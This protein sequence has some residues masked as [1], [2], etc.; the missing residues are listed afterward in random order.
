V[1]GR[2]SQLLVV[3]L[4]AGVVG[5]GALVVARNRTPAAP[6]TPGK[7]A[8]AGLVVY[9]P[10]G[11]SG[12]INIATAQFRQAHPEVPLNLHYDN[13]NVLVKLVLE[14]G[15]RPDVFM[16]PGELELRQISEKGLID[17]ASVRDF[18]TL[19]MVLIAP[20]HPQS[21]AK[22]EK[23]EDL[24][25]PQIRLVSLGDPKYNSVGYYGEQV[26]RKA[27]LWDGLQKKLLLQEGPLNAFKLVE[28]GK[29]DAGLAYLTCPL[30]TN[31]EKAD[32]ASVRIVQKIPRE[33]YSPIR[34]Q[35]GMLKASPHPEEAQAFIDFMASPAVQQAMA[36][37]GV[38]PVEAAK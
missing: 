26:L 29:V 6:D 27:G 38:L 3:V 15:E 1:S 12:P 4:L 16:S 19:D 33:S 24:G 8:P 22:V 23:L 32:K 36:K 35:L 10:C 34:L 20:R 7:P 13:A 25:S 31:P 14:R 37:D 28:S 11:L 9:A 21:K 18:G 17:E 5:L 30:D 2:G